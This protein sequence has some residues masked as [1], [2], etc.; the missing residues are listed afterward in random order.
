MRSAEVAARAGVNVETLRYY[1]RRGLLEEPARL[2]SG[3]R[4]WGHEWVRVVRFIKA[5]QN[6]GFTLAQIATL[7]DLA[8]GGG[9]SCESV[10]VPGLRRRPSR[11]LHL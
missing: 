8:A 7:L 5:A 9:D 2:D 11:L 1:Q 3:Y 10:Q 6:V 4:W